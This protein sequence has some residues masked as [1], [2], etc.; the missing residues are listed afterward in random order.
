[1]SL[2]AGGLLRAVTIG[3]SAT[4]LMDLWNFGLKRTFGSPSLNYCL[5]GRWVLHMP[6]GRFRHASIAAAEPKPHECP[7]GWAAHYATGVVFAVVF[8]VVVAPGAWLE[9]PTLLPALLYGVVTVV[10]PLFVMQPA[11]GLGIASSRAPRPAQAR[12][13]SLGTHIVFGLGLYGS[14]LGLSYVLPTA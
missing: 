6:S 5:L 13:K 9:R 1:M 3:A 10:F 12:L 11:L 8:V 7:T 4:F 2:N 14:A